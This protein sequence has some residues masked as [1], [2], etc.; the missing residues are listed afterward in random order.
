MSF[1]WSNESAFNFWQEQKIFVISTVLWLFPSD[2]VAGAWS[3]SLIS[4][5]HQG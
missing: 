5:Y 4:V 2:Q 1:K 3:Q